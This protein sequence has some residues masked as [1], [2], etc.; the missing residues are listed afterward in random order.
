MYSQEIEE[1]SL[2]YCSNRIKQIGMNS[3]ID[4]IL[5]TVFNWKSHDSPFSQFLVY[6]HVTL[7]ANCPW[8]VGDLSLS[9]T[10]ALLNNLRGYSFFDALVV[11][12]STWKF[13]F[14]FSL[15]ITPS[16][17][18]DDILSTIQFPVYRGLISLFGFPIQFMTIS[19][20]FLDEA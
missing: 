15:M 9:C 10:T 8:C 1:I 11:I 3:R 7:S 18:Y 6:L 19:L 4:R 16:S 5:F 2:F 13:Y 17:L 20:H 12:Q 14:K